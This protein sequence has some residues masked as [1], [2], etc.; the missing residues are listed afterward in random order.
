MLYKYIFI[1]SSH[2]PSLLSLFRSTEVGVNAANF[3]SAKIRISKERGFLVLGKMDQEYVNDLELRELLTSVK[4]D[5]KKTGML[6]EGELRLITLVIYSD[7]FQH[8]GPSQ[9]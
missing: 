2:V 6:K 7:F 5:S 4:L 3:V 9:N 1:G 8:K